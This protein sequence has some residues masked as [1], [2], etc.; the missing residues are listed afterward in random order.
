MTRGC[1]YDILKAK[2]LASSTPT[3]KYLLFD[4]KNL[5]GFLLKFPT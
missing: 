4:Y 5:A 1:H 3:Y 2:D